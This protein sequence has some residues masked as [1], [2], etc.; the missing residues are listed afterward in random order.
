MEGGELELMNRGWPGLGEPTWES[1]ESRFCLDY[2]MTNSEALGRVE[3]GWLWRQ[4]EVV[5]SDHKTIGFEV[6]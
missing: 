1:G 5:E 4:E 6:R 3:Q 2:I